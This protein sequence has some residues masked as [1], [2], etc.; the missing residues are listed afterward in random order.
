[1][2]FGTDFFWYH[3]LITNKTYSVSMPIYGTIFPMRIFGFSWTL[4]RTQ[5]GGGH[6]VNVIIFLSRS[7]LSRGVAHGRYDLV[8][9]NVSPSGYDVGVG[10]PMGKL[11]VV[12]LLG[13]R[14]LIGLSEIRKP[15]DLSPLDCWAWAPWCYHGYWTAQIS[16]LCTSLRPGWVEM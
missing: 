9:M 6:A 16:V 13:Q 2:Q 3:F 10:C 15:T 4:P 8:T 1:M 11:S 14:D 5:R 12:W 7:N